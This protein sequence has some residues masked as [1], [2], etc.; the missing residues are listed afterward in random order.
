MIIFPAFRKDLGQF[1]YCFIGLKFGIVTFLVFLV[2]G[3][4][5]GF[6]Q[7]FFGKRGNFRAQGSFF[8]FKETFWWN[9]GFWVFFMC[10]VAVRMV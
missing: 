2:L 4:H 10:F 8:G 6:E 9:F 7:F 5:F 3:L 1:C